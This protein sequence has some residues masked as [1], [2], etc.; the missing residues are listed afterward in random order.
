MNYH[1]NRNRLDMGV[2]AL[3]ELQ[4][5]HQTGEMTGTE[6][7]WCPGM[8]EWRPLEEVLRQKFPGTRAKSN[9]VLVIACVGAFIAFVVVLLALG[10]ARLGRVIH[11]TVAKQTPLT[12]EN[13]PSP[14][15]ASQS[16]ATA[17]A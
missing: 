12:R 15:R 16:L 3:E 17:T 4:R 2:F 1:L 14:W 10:G 6:L 8:A 11:R 13:K 9:T 7:V 5:R